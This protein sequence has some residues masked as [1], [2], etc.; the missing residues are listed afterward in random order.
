MIPVL[1]IVERCASALDAEQGFPAYDQGRYTFE[2]D[3]KPAINGAQEWLVSVF[4]SVFADNKLSEENLRD[5]SKVRCFLTS[6]YSRVTMDSADLGESVWTINAVY[7]KITSTGTTPLQPDASRSVYAPLVSYITS[8]KSAKRLTLE[9]V[10]DAKTNPFS[11]GNSIQTSEQLIEYAYLNFTDY[12]GGYTLSTTDKTELEILPSVGQELVAIAYLKY[13]A[14]ITVIGG[15]VEMPLTLIDLIVN[16]TLANLNY[17]QGDNELWQRV[18]RD[19][20][21]L[22]T[23]MA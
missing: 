17:K 13:P 8:D 15:N 20:R 7:P 3:Y 14:S 19:Q 4:N 6:Q 5:L 22:I 9:E 18:E 1:T 16:K 12:T 23:L 21:K 2:R 11:P 10:N